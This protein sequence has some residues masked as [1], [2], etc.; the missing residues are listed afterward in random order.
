MVKYAYEIY[1]G[2]FIMNWRR[3]VT[4]ILVKY[5]AYIGIMIAI[6]Y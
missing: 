2:C 1:W 3:D 6:I 5:T 4:M